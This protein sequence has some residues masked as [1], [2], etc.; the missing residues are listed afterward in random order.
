MKEPRASQPIV[1]LNG[2][3][4]PLDRAGISPL[5]RGF[6]HGDGLFETLRA[7]AGR[8]LYW[9]DHVDRL[10]A[11]ASFLRISM[12]PSP[13]WRG[14]LREILQRNRL[15]EVPAR[16]KILVSRGVCEDP[17]LPRG[18]SPSLCV[19]AVP[20]L[21]PSPA[22]YEKGWRLHVAQEGFSSPLSP[23]KTLS[24][25]PFWTAR[26]EALDRGADE[27]V[28]RD[29]AGMVT[30]TSAGSI[31]A[32]SAGRWWTPEA[33]LQLPGITLKQVRRRIEQSG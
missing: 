10:L 24:Y 5:D 31:L 15:T 27:A 4:L 9:R 12:D 7:E 26:Q 8:P 17:G 18:C 20:Y 16:I 11:S 13:D 25:L 1:W 6:Q 19:L 14:L 33:R 21:P 28:L 2:E 30:E 32:R 22:L 3:F 29:P 23:H